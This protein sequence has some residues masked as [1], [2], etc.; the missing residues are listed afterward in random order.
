MTSGIR[1]TD[2][3]LLSAYLDDELSPR[4]RA[5]LEAR[6][7]VEPALQAELD[8]LRRTVQILRAAPLLTPPRS[9]MLD[10]AIYRRRPPWWLRYGAFRLAGALGA[11]TAVLFIA[12]GVILMSRPPAVGSLQSIAYQATVLSTATGASEGE[13]GLSHTKPS[14]APA[15]ALQTTATPVAVSAQAS[16][17]PLATAAAQVERRT[18]PP[19]TASPVDRD[20]G[21]VTVIAAAPPLPFTPTAALALGAMATPAAE[22]LGAA[23]GEATINS[24]R[25]D[26]TAAAN[27]PV[28]SGGPADGAG[29]MM[30]PSSTALAMEPPAQATLEKSAGA[31]APMVAGTPAPTLAPLPSATFRPTTAPSSTPPPGATPTRPNTASVTPSCTIT[32][33][34]SV[35]EITAPQQPLDPTARLLLVAG[36]ALLII[37]LVIF[38]IAWARS[39]L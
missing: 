6:L 29:L 24:R 5:A 17:T 23:K 31:M 37:S 32:P 39:R 1:L 26:E 14:A 11:V 21:S 35:N 30:A 4:E 25:A 8:E 15:A 10:P 16:P 13:T 19:N 2:L 3:E 28:P 36:I 38:S 34:P 18:E 9:F 7:A 12:F 33:S 20:K 22:S 27:V